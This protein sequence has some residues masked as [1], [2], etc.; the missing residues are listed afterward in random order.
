MEFISEGIFVKYSKI[1]ILGFKLLKKSQILRPFFRPSALK[2]YF[3][4][5]KNLTV[6]YMYIEESFDT[7][8]NMGYGSGNSPMAERV[9]WYIFIAKKYPHRG[10]ARCNWGRGGSLANIFC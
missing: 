2:T 3:F 7:N 8:F 9:N 6:G 1:I 5:Q 4:F 10:P